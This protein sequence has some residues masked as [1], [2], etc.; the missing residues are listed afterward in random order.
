[1]PCEKRHPLATQGAEYIRPRRLTKRRRQRHFL[2]VGHFGHVIQAAAA[3]D[4]NLD[5]FHLLALSKGEV[6]ILS[7][8][9]QHRLDESL[10][11]LLA[12]VAGRHV[13]I[14]LEEDQIL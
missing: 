12:D 9:L 2:A 7:A 8:A 11:V 6:K 3:D 5:L 13:G 4:S 1:M 14:V 10:P